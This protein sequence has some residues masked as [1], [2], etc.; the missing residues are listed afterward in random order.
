LQAR[1][2]KKKYMTNRKYFAVG[3]C[4][5]NGS[6]EMLPEFLKESYWENGWGA[7]N[8]ISVN[9]VIIAKTGSQRHPQWMKIRAFGIVRKIISPSK[10]NVEWNV[11]EKRFDGFNLFGTITPL[12]LQNDNHKK[13]I[14]AIETELTTIKKEKDMQDKINLLLASKNLILTGAP[15]T[16]KTYLAKQ[17]AKEMNAEWE[18]V[19]FHPSYDY[20]DFVEGLRPTPPDENGNIGFELKNGVFKKFCM[21]AKDNFENSQ[22]SIEELNKENNIKLFIDD[23][24]NNAIKNNSEFE[25][26]FHKIK[27]WISD[28][29]N[30]TIKIKHGTFNSWD[31]TPKNEYH[32]LSSKDLV[33]ILKNTQRINNKEEFVP[34]L[35][36]QINNKDNYL[37]SLYSQI[38]DAFYS[39]EQIMSKNT[40]KVELKNFVFIIDEINRGEISKIFGELFFSIDPSYRG[41]K[42]KTKTQYA[43]M[44]PDE[45]DFYIPENVYIIGTMNDIDRSVESFDFAMRRRFTWKEITAKDSQRM[46]DGES[47][48]DDAITKMDAINNVIYQDKDNHIEGLNASY[49]IGA[50]YF[51]NY[52]TKGDADDFKNL[53]E[54]RLEPLLKE[55][56]RGMPNAEEDLKKLND[57]Y[58]A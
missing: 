16:G 32:K 49:H 56:L 23:F 50:A 53:W 17:I 48:K 36:R 39:N 55:Y 30:D 58:F 13:M 41:E 18:F 14:D 8:H 43:N 27:F 15:G 4:W 35:N 9:D 54:L 3:T 44:H 10:Y 52:L 42:G 24:L 7:E 21:Q 47:W 1:K 46:F 57:A 20:T 33:V 29:E 22:K 51:K 34:I 6:V 5:E 37:F 2:I 11:K 38:F 40:N 12:N 28:L 31:S 25:T 19:Q 26:T 45:E